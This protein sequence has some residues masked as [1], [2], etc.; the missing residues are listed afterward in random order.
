MSSETTHLQETEKKH[1]NY[2]AVFI[3][4]VVLT[5]IEV[6]IA[7]VGISRTAMVVILL[8]LALLKAGLVAQYFMHLKYDSKFLSVIAYSPVIVASILMLAL[9]LE[10]TFQPHWLF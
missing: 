6:G 1:P 8:V 3:G 7:Q 10:W 9:V 4:L 2:M 5:A